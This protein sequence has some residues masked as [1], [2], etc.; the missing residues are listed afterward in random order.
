MSASQRS[1]TPERG[2][3]DGF[4]TASE[5]TAQ[6]AFW[7]MGPFPESPFGRV[8]R[9]RICGSSAVLEEHLPA[10]VAR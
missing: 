3:C 1:D 4:L 7:F 9:G 8:Q 5:T 10:R 6:L 2:P